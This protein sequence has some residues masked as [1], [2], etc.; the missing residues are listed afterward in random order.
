MIKETIK[1]NKAYV[2][3]IIILFIYLLFAYIFYKKQPEK[4][5]TNTLIVTDNSKYIYNNK[6]LTKLEDESLA[7][8]NDYNIYI[9]NKYIGEYKLQYNDKWYI[10]N[11]Q[12]D[13]IKYEGNVIAFSNIDMNVFDYN[14]IN[15]MDNEQNMIKNYLEK[16][17]ITF[18]D[19]NIYNSKVEIDLDDDGKTEKIYI[20]KS[21]INDNEENIFSMIL[22]EKNNKLIPVISKVIPKNEYSDIDIYDLYGIIDIDKDDKKEIIISKMIYSQPDSSC[23]IIFKYENGKY[24]KL[25]DC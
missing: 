20:I 13:P 16:E 25:V 10:Y 8:W 6:Q 7:N 14:R 17:N 18:V 15:I 19:Y 5:K 1:N 23:E 12:R 9:N 22:V 21:K 24:N 4:K 11:E 3:I 2:A